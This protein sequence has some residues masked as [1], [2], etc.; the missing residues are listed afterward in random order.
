MSVT[1]QL[2]P[3]RRATLSFSRKLSLPEFAEFCAK[4]PDLVV[5]REPDGKITIMTPVGFLRMAWATRPVPLLAL[6][7]LMVP[8]APPML[9]G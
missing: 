8:F 1:V 5:E 9:Y 7:Y 6:R 2:P 4:N 3:D